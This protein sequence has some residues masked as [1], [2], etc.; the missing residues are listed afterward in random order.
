MKKINNYEQGYFSIENKVLSL[1]PHLLKTYLYINS[2]DFK[3]GG[4]WHSQRKLADGLGI[5]VRSLQRHLKELCS[6][7]FITKERRGFN[8]TNL[9]KCLVGIVEKVKEKKEELTTNFKKSFPKTTTRKKLKFNNFTGRNYSK[10][11]W[12]KLE[13]K[14]LGWE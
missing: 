4:I 11:E 9:M 7:N 10:E 6:M 8:K 12:D 3:R 5:S 2:L 1:K 13:N 14:L